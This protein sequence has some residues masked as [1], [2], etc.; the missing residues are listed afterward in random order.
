MFHGGEGLLLYAATGCRRLPPRALS[1]S[2][3]PGRLGTHAEIA[4]PAAGRDGRERSG[5]VGGAVQ[6]RQW[7]MGDR[8]GQGLAP[9]SFGL[10]YKPPRQCFNFTAQTT[11]ALQVVS[12]A[13]STND[14]GDCLFLDALDCRT[15]SISAGRRRRHGRVALSKSR[16]HRHC[17]D[18]GSCCR[19]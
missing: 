14:A 3:M 4:G 17:H 6:K 7:V 19:I 10:A 15:P 5:G 9:T 13:F 12:R 11:P 8:D 1:P 18:L 16:R 2:F